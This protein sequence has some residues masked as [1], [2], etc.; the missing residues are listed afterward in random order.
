MRGLIEV[1]LNTQNLCPGIE[2]GWVDAS[3]DVRTVPGMD[4]DN[5]RLY[6]IDEAANLLGC[7]RYW[8][9][10]QVTAG[11]VPHGR[12]GIRKGV[13]F[14]AGDL[15]EIVESRRRPAK[16]LP[17]PNA[18]ASGAVTPTSIPAEFAALRSARA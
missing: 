4:I 1:G 17:A 3:A 14:T 18:A 7:S 15:L 11:T 6:S 5:S 12:R 2:P 9:R 10:D 8:L 16:P 13:F